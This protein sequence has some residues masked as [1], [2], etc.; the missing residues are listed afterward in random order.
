VQSEINDVQEEI[1]SA[2]GR[3]NYLT[4]SS[5]YSTVNLTFYEV[6]NASAVNNDKPSFATRI[7]SA[8]SSGWSWVGELFVGL[9]FYM[10]TATISI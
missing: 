6:L 8:F 4:H 7:S 5:D 2:T 3:V 1:E 9:N 10:A